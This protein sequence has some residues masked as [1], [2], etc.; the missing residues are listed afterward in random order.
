MSKI[1]G[2]LFCFGLIITT[3][4]NAFMNRDIDLNEVDC[5][6][7]MSKITCHSD[8]Y[9]SGYNASS[10]EFTISYRSIFNDRRN[11]ISKVESAAYQTTNTGLLAAATLGLSDAIL[12]Q[13]NALAAR[14]EAKKD[15][16]MRI[17]DIK[18]HINK[19]N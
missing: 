9:F 17:A 19:C 6:N 14:I 10:C 12:N 15:I 2:T 3:Q 5:Y 4:A 13:R 8:G 18:T 11:M 1:I 16:K 7:S